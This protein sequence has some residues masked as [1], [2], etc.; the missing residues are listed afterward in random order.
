[1]E[2]VGN[3]VHRRGVRRL[4]K[5]HGNRGHLQRSATVASNMTV[6]VTATSIA[7]PTKSMSLGRR[8]DPAPSVTTTTLADENGGTAYNATLQGGGGAG[9]LTWALASGSS[10]P[11]GLSLSSAGAISGT[12]TA[13]GTPN[14]R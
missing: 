7:D 6:S 9:S 11:A 1:M 5:Q 3:N 2:R 8:R 13:A 12:P 4:H 14:S 10:L